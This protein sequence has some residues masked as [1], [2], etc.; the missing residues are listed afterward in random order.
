MPTLS[1]GMIVKDEEKNLGR[2]LQSVQGCFDEIVIVDTGSKDKTKEIA[3]SFGA[4]IYDFEW[5][6]DF[7]AARNFAFS[8]AKSDYVMWLDADDILT[9]QDRVRLQ[10]L[11]YRLGEADAYLMKYDV[12]RDEFGN[13]TCFFFRHRIV[14]NNGEAKWAAP[15]HE[16]III[17]RHWKQADTN[18]IVTHSPSAE[19][20]AHDP[21]R[22]VRLLRKAVEKCP[23][24]RRL[25]FYLAKE[26]SYNSATLEE[27][28]SKFEEYLSHEDWHENRVNA[29]LYL[30]IDHWKLGKTEKAIETCLRG[31]QLDPR[32][33]EFYVTIGQIYYDQKDW[34][35]AVHWFEL[36]TRCTVPQTWGFV[37]YDNY[38]WVPW[39]RLCVAYWQIGEREKSYDANERALKY[40]PQDPRFLSNREVMKNLMFT[41]RTSD[42]AVRLNVGSTKFVPS[43]RTCNT[44]AGPVVD[45]VFPLNQIPYD[46][47]T[48]HAIYCDHSIESLSADG[49]RFAIA[50]WARVL[51]HNGE[52]ILKVTDLDLCC[53]AFLREEDRSPKGNEDLGPKEWFRHVIYGSSAPGSAIPERRTAFTKGELQR[54]LEANGFEVASLRNY[55][56]NGTPSIEVLAYQKRKPLRVRWL[57]GPVT[58]DDHETRVRRIHVQRYMEVKGVDSKLVML[59][60]KTEEDKLFSELK[61]SDI[62]VMTTYGD[63]ENRIAE[64]LKRSGI[65]VVYDLARDA[66]GNGQLQSLLQSA[67]TVV[68][69]SSALASSKSNLARTL[70]IPDSYELSVETLGH[71]YNLHGEGGKLRAV[72]CGPSSDAVALDP[73][74]P[75][76]AAL[77][78]ELRVIS[79][80]EKADRKWSRE[81]WLADLSDCDVAIFPES[82][83]LQESIVKSNLRVT[84]AQSLGLPVLV[85]PIPSYKEAVS[86][87]G[88]GFVCNVLDDWKRFLAQLRDD[89][90]LRERV[91]RAAKV[92]VRKNYSIDVVGETWI[93][94]LEALSLECCAPPKVDIV[95]PTYNNLKYLKLCVDSVRKGTAWPYNLIVVDS[96]SDDTYEWLSKQ[97]D[98][99]SYKS[100]E[101]L[102]FSAATNAGINMAKEKFVM[103]LNNDTIVA[104]GWLTAM[105]YEAMK[106]GVGAVGPFSNN[107]KNWMHSELVV[108]KGKEIGWFSSLEDVKDLIP[109]IQSYRHKKE[110]SDRVWIPFYAT[111]FS[112]A[113]IEQIGLLDEEYKSGC[114]DVDY[115][116]RLRDRGYRVV[117]TYD[118]FVFHFVSKTLNKD[119]EINRKLREQEDSGNR[120]YYDWKYAKPMAI[121]LTGKSAEKWNPKTLC[122]QS[123]MTSEMVASNV[124][125]ELLTRGYRS[126]VFADCEGMEGTYDDV[127]YVDYKK[128][129][130]FVDASYMSLFISIGN[131]DSFQVPIRA[132]HKLCMLL[133]MPLKVAGDVVKRKDVVL[134]VPDSGSDELLKQVGVDRARL[135]LIQN[136]FHEAV[137]R[138]DSGAYSW[139]SFVEGLLK[140]KDSRKDDV[141]SLQPVG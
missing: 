10:D 14:R 87:E 76:L 88:T 7:S 13:S 46:D 37:L 114:E 120:A 78:V 141:L 65:A 63:L 118:A 69:A 121:I 47:S 135:H 85:S 18:I 72:W 64:R 8:K 24:D 83:W 39:D 82:H 35:K 34:K 104:D 112:R 103:T 43:Y 70:T 91:G 1:L 49:A 5:I 67:S 75:V 4:M 36:A 96:G 31:I 59:N 132:D 19:D 107:E 54:I 58:E 73:L 80:S 123:S 113:I 110:V 55:D 57:L 126:F 60:F 97:D 127:I 119:W 129:R 21:G 125:K 115:C 138:G 111:L 61:K 139:N 105:M 94:L 42:R 128:F 12:S 30:A 89:S 11:H 106:P 71:N 122:T 66:Q 38:T 86:K 100:P 133:D 33:A 108:V 99:I 90:S 98:I 27:S 29:F 15:I 117:Q 74:R 81:T 136:D 3:Q 40:R 17:P 77:G 137:S 51:R 32:W 20:L 79:D 140:A 101:R 41:G 23:D 50:E 134:V 116:R 62:V 45:E 44:I 48:V 25:Q 102:H 6:D 26:L 84:Q 68:C 56:S 22:N 109:D 53:E 16:C 28:I 92:E 130:K 9:P 2:C 131:L 52:L 95:I 124:A 93:K